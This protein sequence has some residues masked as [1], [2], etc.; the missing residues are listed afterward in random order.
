MSW[1]NVAERGRGQAG[2]SGDGVAPGESGPQGPPAT[3]TLGDRFRLQPGLQPRSPSP[4]LDSI[5][6]ANPFPQHWPHLTR[7]CDVHLPAPENVSKTRSRCQ[8]LTRLAVRR[9]R[10]RDNLPPRL[11][12][13]A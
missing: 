3:T 12:V 5:G 4:S 10:G 6:V 9:R 8:P 1:A 13:V 11:A 7:H 2:R